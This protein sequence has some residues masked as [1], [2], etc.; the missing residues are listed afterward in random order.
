MRGRRPNKGVGRAP[1]RWRADRDKLVKCVN[2]AIDELKKAGVLR[3]L[4][5]K[6]LRVYT[7]IPVIKP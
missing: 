5:K 2:K 6:Y 3:N 7:S 4:A 1:P